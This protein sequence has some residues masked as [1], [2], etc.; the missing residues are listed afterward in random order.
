MSKEKSDKTIP[1][2]DPYVITVEKSPLSLLDE[3][4]E[5]FQTGYWAAF[6]EKFGWTP[7]A[8]NIK[9]SKSSYPLLVLVR[10]I[11]P[12]YLVGYVPYGPAVPDPGKT[13]GEYLSVL[14]KTLFPFLP[15]SV[16]FLRFDLPWIL[17]EGEEDSLMVKAGRHG[18]KAP[19]D[20]QPPVT[21]LLDLT[22]SEEAM[23][24]QMKHKTRYNIKLAEKKGVR[25]V[26]KDASGLEEWYRIYR[27]TALRDKIVLHSFP[28]YQNLFTL[29]KDYR[30]AR[31]ELKLY[32]SEAEGETLGGIIVAH[33]KT[34]ALY[35]Y[36]ASSNKKRN[37][38][39][40]HALQWTAVTKAKEAGCRTYDFF[41]I[42]RADDPADPMHGLYRFKTGFGGIVAVRPGCYDYPKGFLLYAGYVFAEKARKFYYK[43]IRKKL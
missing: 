7:F 16:R 13:R 35:M 18:R 41:G 2:M 37:W 6:K 22:G 8:F 30:G 38:M 17:K 28:Y 40:N 10:K 34:R 36:G 21:V 43:V 1:M 23:L 39:P 4:P 19:M 24:K 11:A 12:M 26:E 20:I 32:L 15:P 42:P 5:L 3:S 33:F 25:I 9:E 29:G 31:P 27:E 14:S